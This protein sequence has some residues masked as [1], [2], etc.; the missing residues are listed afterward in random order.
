[1]I[2][3]GSK[4]KIPVIS[5]EIGI[6]VG[7][8]SQSEKSFYPPSRYPYLIKFDRGTFEFGN[9]IEVIETGN[10]EDIELLDYKPFPYSLEF[11]ELAVKYPII[12][13]LLI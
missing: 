5:D 3:L 2:P 9:G 11:I 10:G 6:V 12:D 7:Y 8:N 4:V 1:M 13:R